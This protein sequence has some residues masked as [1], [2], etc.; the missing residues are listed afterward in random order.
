MKLG[1]VYYLLMAT[2]ALIPTITH[3]SGS[4]SFKEISENIPPAAKTHLT[5]AFDIAPIGEGTRLGRHFA[6]VSGARIGPYFFEATSRAADGTACTITILMKTSILNAN[7][8]EIKDPGTAVEIVE[9]FDS[10]IVRFSDNKKTDKPAQM[11]RPSTRDQLSNATKEEVVDAVRAVYT[12]VSGLEMEFDGGQFE[13]KDEPHNG[14]L[15]RGFT[16]NGKAR[17]I[18]FNVAIG[19]HGGY[20][21]EIFTDEDEVP[22]FVLF[23]ESYWSFDPND[24]NKTIENIT[25]RRFYFA[26]DGS[27]AKALQKSFSG[28]SEKELE[29]NRDQAKNFNFK[30][31]KF[32]IPKFFNA[33]SALVRAENRE[34]EKISNALWQAQDQMIGH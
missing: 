31:Q 13:A 9:S 24:S 6:E 15:I 1:T 3:A 4:V 12:E 19:D 32:G 7:G 5:S 26:P 33:L 22:S 20:T 28:T 8:K 29:R 27:L 2:L 10:F 25:E 14:N 16:R 17:K 23:E 30:A 21:V 34:L 11:P 18:E